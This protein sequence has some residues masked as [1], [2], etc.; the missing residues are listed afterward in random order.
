MA[1]RIERGQ[2]TIDTAI[3]IAYKLLK[4]TAEQIYIG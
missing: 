1:K 3:E 4:E 2:Y